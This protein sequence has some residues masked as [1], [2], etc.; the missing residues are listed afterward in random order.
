VLTGVLMFLWW[1]VTAGRRRRVSAN[2][3]GENRS[4]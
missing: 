1:R 2:S 3:A 4:R